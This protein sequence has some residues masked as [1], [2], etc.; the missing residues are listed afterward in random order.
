MTTRQIELAVEALVEQ[1]K[2]YLRCA[3]CCDPEQVAGWTERAEACGE[4]IKLFEG[5]GKP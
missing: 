1:Q 2:F 3:A 4:A 5:M